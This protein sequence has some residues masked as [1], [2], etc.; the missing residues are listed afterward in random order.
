MFMEVNDYAKSLAAAREQYNESTQEQREN[1]NKELKDLEKTHDYKE[2]KQANAFDEARGNIEKDTIKTKATYDDKTVDAIDRQTKDFNRR[3]AEGREDFNKER[4]ET[5]RDFNNRLN[6]ISN[7]YKGIQTEREGAYVDKQGYDKKHYTKSISGLVE[8]QNEAVNNVKKKNDESMGKTQSAFEFE[9]DKFLTEQKRMTNEARGE[10][11]SYSGRMRELRDNF[12]HAQT[13]TKQSYGDDLKQQNETHKYQQN[14]QSNTYLGDVKKLEGD[15]AYSQERNEA[16][17]KEAIDTSKY[18]FM[19]KLADEKLN[20]N[21]EKRR[22]NRESTEKIEDIKNSYLTSNTELKRETDRSIRANRDR[23]SDQIKKLNTD[24]N[25]ANESTVRNA[26]EN[27]SKYRTAANEEKR[28]I[29]RNNEDEKRDMGRDNMEKL[30]TARESLQG[31][32]ARQRET[33]RNEMEA[34]QGHFDGM[35]QG[36]KTNHKASMDEREASF[37][38]SSDE[39]TRLQKLNEEKI[40]KEQSATRSEAET[41]HMNDIGFLKEQTNK[42]V[43]GGVRGNSAADEI[44]RLQDDRKALNDRQQANLDSINYKHQAQNEKDHDLQQGQMR[45]AAAL[46]RLGFDK[47]G[48]EFNEVRQS[49]LEKNRT[50]RQMQIDQYNKNLST[51]TKTFEET[52]TREAALNKQRAEQLRNEFAKTMDLMD[53]KNRESLNTVQTESRRDKINFLNQAAKDLYNSQEDI[54][55]ENRKVI[56]RTAQGYEQRLSSLDE[57]KNK[58]VDRYE[59][60]LNHQHKKTSKEITLMAESETQRKADD[61][62]AQRQLLDSKETDAQKRYLDLKA[63]YDMTMEKTKMKQDMQTSKLVEGYEDKIANMTREHN[64]EMA[65][66]IN[67]MSAEYKRLSEFSTNSL[68]QQKDQYDLRIE[69]MRLVN[70]ENIEKLNRRV[71]QAETKNSGTGGDNNLG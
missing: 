64:T 46:S 1:Y 61:R 30:N 70:H 69:K 4:V 42:A 17:M 5:K 28:K 26:Y 50:E 31:E 54:K 10:G 37:V 16:K 32:L 40:A 56:E 60:K 34:K 52:N 38:K 11:D 21:E 18:R 27:F 66:R 3:I 59:K 35:S 49:D 33:Y 6:E 2:T 68:Q 47:Q 48:K 58:L 45:E 23:T 24:H 39:L 25:E 8:K 29:V 19:N 63:N 22:V 67:E 55:D 65:R 51:A 53:Q 7:S 20:S 44:A 12:N 36:M 57:T 43:N 9:R 62:R 13:E 41:R 14:K 15:F 71:A